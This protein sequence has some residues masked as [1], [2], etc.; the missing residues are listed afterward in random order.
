MF[1]SAS[2]GLY[3]YLPIADMRVVLTRRLRSETP[4]KDSTPIALP[5]MPGTSPTTVGLVGSFMSRTIVGWAA[6]LL[7]TYRQSRIVVMPPFAPRGTLSF[8]SSSG[9]LAISWKFFIWPPAGILSIGVRAWTPLYASGAACEQ[10]ETTSSASGSSVSHLS[11]RGAGR[12]RG[13]CMDP[14]FP[15]PR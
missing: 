7:P 12:E 13:T 1:L 14:P 4:W 2:V 11:K 10:A 9:L 3:V 15:W 8:G 6:L 5:G